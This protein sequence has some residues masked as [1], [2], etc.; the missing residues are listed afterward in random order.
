MRSYS[1]LIMMMMSEE[2]NKNM[3]RPDFALLPHI[4]GAL[5]E[6]FSFFSVCTSSLSEVIISIA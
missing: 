2:E 3:W 6:Q 4:E 5:K 1:E